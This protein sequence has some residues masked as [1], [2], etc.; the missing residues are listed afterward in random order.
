MGK[1]TKGTMHPATRAVV[2]AIG[3]F[4]GVRF[5]QVLFSLIRNKLIAVFIGPAGV[6]LVILYNSVSD[7]ISSATRLNIDQSAMR[8]I[9]QSARHDD[10][11]TATVVTVWTV[12]LGV[13]GMLLMCACSPLLSLWSFGDT[14]RWWTYCVLSFVPLAYAINVGQQAIMQGRGEFGRMAHV[15][16][17]TAVGGIIISVPIII[18]FG[19]ASIVWV[20]AA[21]GAMSL[22]AV[23]VCRTHFRRVRMSVAE[24][25]RRGQNFV[26]LGIWLTAGLSVMPLVNYLFVIFLNDTASTSQLGI[27]QAG[28]TIV[29]TYL[30]VIFT[31]VWIEYYPHLSAVAHS[32]Q[33]VNTVVSHRV[34]TLM[35]MCLP[36]VPLFMAV[37]SVLVM[38]VY[39]GSFLDMIPYIVPAVGALP[40][41]VTAWCMSMA[42]MAR[43]DGATY[44]VVE[45][46]SGLAFIVTAII[47]FNTGS[48]LGL[49]IAYFVWH[50][51]YLATVWGVIRFRY[52]YRLRPRVTV[53]VAGITVVC[54]LS[55]VL[56][57]TIGWTAPLL[58]AVVVLPYAYRH[59][60]GSTSKGAAK[61]VSP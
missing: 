56:R 59:L 5:L 35:W 43:G 13:L 52:G 39:S 29:N 42:I 32:R 20:I 47:G 49:G 16:I 38:I 15:G 44:A 31:G 53:V 51:I 2:K 46:V 40:L 57:L 26:R 21:Y 8:D 41:R 28:Y 45:A 27:Y 36:V 48:F 9:A 4:G 23:L 34:F 1:M 12:F 10:D 19:A 14:D 6:G 7:L 60:F 50:L 17:I 18:L 55:A 54:V 3:I 33:R 24:I 61:A 58:I 11:A 22:I 30:G 37:A 25:W